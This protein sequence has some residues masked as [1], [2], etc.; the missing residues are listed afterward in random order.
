[1]SLLYLEPIGGIAGDMF[2]A[3]CLDLGLP[4]Q[5]LLDALA[6]LG[7][8]GW[9][10]AVTRAERHSISGT[11]VDVV[12]TTP[13]PAHDRTWAEVRAMIVQSGLSGPIQEKALRVFE[14]LAIAEAHVHGTEVD[15]VHFH[16]VG[17]IDSIVDICGAAAAVELLGNPEIFAGPP[18]LGSGVG[19]SRHGA[20][21]I[22]GPATLEILKGRPVKFEGVGELT[23][24]TGAAILA[25]LT[26]AQPVPP[27]TPTKVG[28]GIGTKDFRDRPNLLRATLGERMEA[29]GELWVLEANLDDMNPQL[30]G[31]LFDRL[32]EAGALDVWSAPLLMKKGRPGQL[33]GVLCERPRRASLEQILFE[34]ST[35]LGVRAHA[36]ERRAL[37]RAW[38]TVETRHGPVRV[39]EGRLEGRL[40]N[41]QP[42][43]EDAL[44]AARARGVPVKEVIA[45]AVARYKGGRD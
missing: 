5:A 9:E 29:P 43:Y 26:S 3:A 38:V 40:V 39:K 8:P 16:E 34:E 17:A 35:T 28:F 20:I 44:A 10:L 45:D 4:K 1:M 27:F 22:P 6:P 36:V 30:F 32:L 2:L 11:H 13:D 19:R 37:D 18:P 15:S 31:P 21:P 12:M 25:G 23:T 41:A 24:P 42:E 7:L 14:K 33:L